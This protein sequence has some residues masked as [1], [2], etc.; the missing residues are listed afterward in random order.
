MRNILSARRP[1]AR[2]FALVLA[3]SLA[4]LACLPGCATAP[5]SGRVGPGA[6]LQEFGVPVVLDSPGVGGNLHDHLQVRIQYK[7]RNARTLNEMTQSLWRKAAMG[8]EYFAFKTGPL[9]M[10]PSQLGA[11]A[12][13]AVKT[14]GIGI[15]M[16][17]D[18]SGSRPQGRT[19]SPSA[20]RSSSSS[21]AIGS[22]RTGS[23]KRRLRAHSPPIGRAAV[24]RTNTPSSFTRH[25]AWTGP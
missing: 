23:R 18:T 13:R 11:F 7:V 5:A 15:I 22:G 16:T 6:L 14:A 9:T 10:P 12:Q 19:S 8:L 25:S 4:A 1:A 20:W 3:A 2:A 21:S 24:S 17:P